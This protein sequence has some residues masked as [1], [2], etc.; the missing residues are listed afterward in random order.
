M[1]IDIM[2]AFFA[3]LD[4]ALRQAMRADLRGIARGM[5]VLL[6]V[7]LLIAAPIAAQAQGAAGTE[8]GYVLG[9]DDT[10]QV[11]VYGQPE[12]GITTRIKAD[13]TIVMPLIGTLTA[14]GLT[15]IGLAK[16][17][18][19]KLTAGGFLKNPVVNV[20]IAAY[21]SKSVNVAG[22]VTTPGI[23]PLDRP[24][25]ALD[26]LL[27]AGWIRDAGASYAY[28]RRAGIAE[29]RLDTEE[30]VRGTPDANPVL[31]DGDTLF[32]PDADQFFIYGQ[33]AR[34]GNFA[35]LPRMTVREALAIA[36]GVSATGQGNKV[37]LVR[38]S[39]K[40]VDADLS[41]PV[42]KGDVII[43]KERLF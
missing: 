6:A 36:G 32:V 1:N 20:E 15:N 21:V 24:Y 40:E 7:P 17:I 37:G 35:V 30:L 39:A 22:R 33:I 42:Q 16:L 23:Y 14:S 29:K 34:A 11:V 25:R 3:R 2:F 38:G 19:D 4:R 12:A 41:T 9:A 31:R 28:L 5:A 26:V 18:T 43:V 27:K 8:T 13:G 10:I